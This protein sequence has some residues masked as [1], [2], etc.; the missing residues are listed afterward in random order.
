MY[1]KFLII[2]VYLFISSTCHADQTFRRG[3]FDEP[4]TL[5]P[6]QALAVSD[7]NILYDLYEGLMT[8]D[9][10]GKLILGQAKSYTISNDKKLYTFKLHPDLKWSNGKKL[11]AY[12]FA[13]SIKRAIDPKIGSTNYFLLEPI[14]NSKNIYS[15]KQSIEELG[16]K[17]IDEQTI[18]IELERP[19]PY[20]LDL[21]SSP[22]FAPVYLNKDGKV[23]SKVSNGPFNLQ[24]WVVNSHISVT[25]NKNYSNAN[26]VKLDK[27]IFYPINQQS[28]ELNRYRAGELD[29]TNK[30]LFTELEWVKKNIPQELHSQ[31]MLASYYYSF[32]VT[33]PPF[34]DNKY[35]RKALAL[36]IDK[37]V[38]A[39]KILGGARSGTENF[40]P[41]GINNY[42]NLPSSAQY[43]DRQR[44]AL[45]KKYFKLA[46]YDV[47][48]VNKP[49]K[50]KLFFHTNEANRIIATAIASMWKKTLGVRTELI[51]QEWKVFLRTRL[52]RNTTQIIREGWI[53]QYDDPL[54][55]LSLF[56]SDNVQNASGFSNEMYD[57]LIKRAENSE[58]LNSRIK[59][60]NQAEQ[61][62]LEE[63]PVVPIY[64]PEVY[65]LV[66]PYIK[67]FNVDN[68]DRTFDRYISKEGL[69]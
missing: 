37:N 55:F 65:H 38:I 35:F 48:N 23:D 56:V 43:T 17:A 24:E 18:V 66:K 29:Y 26:Q 10:N 20:I 50:V 9:N 22:T 49:L 57:N 32:N 7:T 16:V 8:Y 6:Q 12:D 42:E 53:A 46:G 63:V 62:L 67:G 41:Q 15:G 60:L 25:K 40:V 13:Q 34:K 39:Q 68:R 27:V 64:T 52:D 45:A 4:D 51:N 3:N 19:T 2:L 11:T 21:L 30:V 61:I 44:I 47:N 54:T 36:A 28:V 14:K 33:K 5:D 58:N 31:P 69:E 59:L 1:N